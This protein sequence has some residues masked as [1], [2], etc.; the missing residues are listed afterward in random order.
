MIEYFASFLSIILPGSP[1]VGGL[2]GI[3]MAAVGM[4]SITGMIMSSDAYGP[5]VDNAAGIAEQSG[6]GDEVV[7]IGD[8]LDAAGNTAKAITKGFAIGAAALQVLALFAVFSELASAI[9]A[10]TVNINLMNP[11]VS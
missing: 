1:I 11:L 7:A 9:T 4:L 5:I 2:Y 3:S 6:L 10:Y 8:K